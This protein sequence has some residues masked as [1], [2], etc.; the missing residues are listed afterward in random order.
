MSGKERAVSSKPIGERKIKKKLIW[1][2]DATT[3]K[4]PRLRQMARHLNRL[5]S[6][7][8]YCVEPVYVVSPA[9]LRLV[10]AKLP[11]NMAE[12]QAALKRT[13]ESGLNQLKIRNLLNPKVI[14]SPKLS[15]KAAVHALIT[16]AKREGAEAIVVHTHSKTALDRIL[17]GSFAE[18]LALNT[19]MP[20]II[21]SP[22]AKAEGAIHTVLFPT[23]FSAESKQAL[24]TL[25]AWASGKGKV[26]IILFHQLQYVGHFGAVPM[27]AVPY[28]VYDIEAETKL[29][30]RTGVKWTAQ[31]R[32]KKLDA[33]FVIGRGVIAVDEGIRKAAQKHKADLI[34]L[35]SRSGA[36]E[37][38]LL[39]SVTRFIIRYSKLPVWVIHPKARTTKRKSLK[40]NLSM[41][42]EPKEV[43]RSSLH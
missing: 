5:T 7:G 1:G 41:F 3:L 2:V 42:Q 16:E 36:V 20:A 31:L 39:G 13:L 12:M 25:A 23:D 35:A 32:E 29:K 37:S 40:S 9:D 8:E 11:L 14:H 43:E 4:A 38:T 30:E 33:E 17:L 10:A 26:R 21:I 24:N 28:P 15:V 19:C 18:T 6:G 34:A 22:E 27:G